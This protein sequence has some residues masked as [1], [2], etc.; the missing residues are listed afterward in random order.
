MK[1]ESLKGF[2]VNSVEITFIFKRKKASAWRLFCVLCFL[3]YCFKS[4]QWK[5]KIC[6]RKFFVLNAFD[7]IFIAIYES[8]FFFERI[9]RRKRK[10]KN[11]EGFSLVNVF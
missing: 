2:Y 7:K 1:E 9:L 6:C 4:L 5:L 3:K 8:S 11:I 10:L